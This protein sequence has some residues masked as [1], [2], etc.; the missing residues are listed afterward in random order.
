MPEPAPAAL[1]ADGLALAS[2]IAAAP[3]P[4]GSAAEASARA[5]LAER[6]AA[7]GFTVTERPFE[8]SE[9]PGRW[10]TPIVGAW[11][12][13]AAFGGAVAVLLRGDGRSV[14]IA[15]AA[16]VLAGGAGWWLERWGTR[17]L[18]VCRRSGTNL[19]ARR[20]VPAVWLVAHLDSKSQ[21]VSLALRAGGVVVCA[22]GWL[23]ALV[24]WGVARMDGA[25][26]G[27]FVVLGLL[28][29]GIGA[30]P[31]AGSLVG[32]NGTGALDNCSGVVAIFEAVTCL[33]P[34]AQVGVLV[35]TAEEL[36]LAGAR[37]WGDTMPAGCAIN[38]D[39]IDDAGEI[40]CLVARDRSGELRRA[41]GL[42]CARE[43]RY[44][45][46]RSLPGVLFDS[47]ALADAGWDVMTVTRGRLS[48]LGRVHTS[49]DTLALW[50][51]RGV[52]ETA[53]FVAGVAGAMIAKQG[54]DHPAER[55]E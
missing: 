42:A 38:C 2:A 37:A 51:G 29:A 53:T 23:V 35:T 13:L 17:S 28:V 49:R 20:G 44:R 7:L 55:E 46:R 12:A 21:P 11:L 1:G 25:P 6:L 22:L 34:D 27:G 50:T 47:V 52:P 26:P 30:L 33:P 15:L 3:R 5:L 14:A 9:L 41:I 43:V 4:A 36:A 39:G 45:T 19:E 24:A 40:V 16:T 48:S 18:R 8:Y 31:L 10:G 54:N 32:S